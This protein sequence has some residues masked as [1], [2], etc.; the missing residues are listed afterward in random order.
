MKTLRAKRILKR[1]VGFLLAFILFFTGISMFGSAVVFR[2]LFRRIDTLPVYVEI[3]YDEIAAPQ[4]RREPVSFLSGE[5]RLSGWLYG[6]GEN[7]LVVIAPG[8]NSNSETHLAEVMFFRDNGYS[9][10]AYTGTGFCDSE[11]EGIVGLQQ[12]KLDLLAALDFVSTDSRTSALPVILY[13][14]SMGGYAAASVLDEAQVSGAICVSGFNAPVETMYRLA[15]RYVGAAA[16]V[17][18]PFLYLQNIFVFGGDADDSAVESINSVDTP[19]LIVQGTQDAVVTEDVSIFSHE[20]EITNPN[21]DFIAVDAPNRSGHRS[22]WLSD[23]AAAYVAGRQKTLEQLDEQYG[24]AIPQEEW[25]AFYLTLDVEKACELDPQFKK[26]VLQFCEDSIEVG[27][28][29]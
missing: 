14:H 12:S 28:N 23:S 1:V 6:G 13:G 26:A 17:E 18:Y 8:M 21:A 10:L 11:G 2:V 4:Y 9:V 15:R 29:K 5:N 24:G 3:P 16:D 7:G 20:D 19:V 27:M 22:V 25:D